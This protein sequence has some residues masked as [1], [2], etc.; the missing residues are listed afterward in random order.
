MMVLVGR[1][2]FLVA[3]FLSRFARFASLL[4]FTTLSSLLLCIYE[5]RLFLG[6]LAVCPLNFALI[7]FAMPLRF[8]PWPL[9][10][11]PL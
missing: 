4:S 6:R 9:A 2:H 8:V 5:G 1:S 3:L 7:R 11:F 10:P